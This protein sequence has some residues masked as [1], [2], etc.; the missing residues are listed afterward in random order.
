MRGT[1]ARTDAR[2]GSG[3][4]A[5]VG[6]AVEAL[7]ADPANACMVMIA[8]PG[9]EERMGGCLAAGRG[10]F[11]V[12]QA[13]DAEPCPFSPFSMPN[14]AQVRLLGALRS[15]F[16]ARVREVEARHAGEAMS[17]CTLFSHR[18]EVLQARLSQT[19]SAGRAPGHRSLSRVI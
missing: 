19:S 5:R 14:V 13:G 18:S 16:F 1:P 6:R 15:P 9:N 10:F 12:S 3:V 7:R 11:H 4:S 2:R 17:G 8:F